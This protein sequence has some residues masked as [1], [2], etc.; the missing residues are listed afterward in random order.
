MYNTTLNLQRCILSLQV[1]NN[2][3]FYINNILNLQLIKN[4]KYSYTFIQ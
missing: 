1:E 2:E 3:R 4:E